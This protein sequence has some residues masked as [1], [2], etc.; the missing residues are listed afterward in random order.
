[1]RITLAKH[2][3]F[4]FGVRDAVEVARE[5]AREHGKLYMLGHI[6]HNE[7]V[8][9]EL[10]DFGVT[11]VNSIHDVKGAPV[12][13]RAHGTPPAVWEEAKA[14]GLE[15]IDATCPLVH[16]I[17][18]E[19]RKMEQD[20]RQIYIIGDKGH[21]EVVGIQSQV[22]NPIIISTPEEARRLRKKKRGG[23]VSQSTQEVENVQEIISI[24][25]MKV[26]DLQFVNT[27]CHPTRQN[28]VELKDLANSNDV[29]IVIGSYTSANTK[30]LTSLARQINPNSYQVETAGDIDPGW[31][32]G[33]ASV[34][35]HAGASTPDNTIDEVM[36]KIQSV[37]SD[38][39]AEVI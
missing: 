39:T 2:A 13:F 35:V 3:G 25:I 20:G 4:C 24:L 8:V 7:R 32:R 12:L 23:A 29:M 18:A 30:R 14:R 11:V 28:Q 10:A 22:E 19:V 36:Q 21:D 16:E 26:K 15:I 33:T 37:T 31:F 17:H 6:V 5:A 9:Q 38:R 27:V 1:M 34:G